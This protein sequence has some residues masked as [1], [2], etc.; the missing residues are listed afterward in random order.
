MLRT[1]RK[2]TLPLLVLAAACGGAGA[3]SAGD[4]WA[5]TIDT[6]GG[7]VI[8][9]NP[10]APLWRAGEEWRIEED[11][12]IGA[13]D[14]TG[15]DVF[16]N[17]SALAVAENGD[18]AV[19]DVQAFEVR[20]FDRDGRHLRSFGRSGS[21]PGEFRNPRSVHFDAQG[22]IWV[23]DA[24]N[25]RY[26]IFSREGALV[27]SRARPF[28]SGGGG[29]NP[30]VMTLDGRLI[31]VF[32]T[33]VREPDGTMAISLI[34]ARLA[35]A[36]GAIDTFP[37]L[38]FLRVP[39]PNAPSALLPF[40]P[41]TVNTFDLHGGT[42]F[43]PSNG[44]R[45]HHR[46]PAGDTTR[47]IEWSRVARAFAR[48][49]EDSV[50]TIIAGWPEP[51]DRAALGIGPQRIRG[52]HVDE[53]GRLFVQSAAEHVAGAGTSFEAFDADGRHL[54]RIESNVRF[55]ATP[56]PL[57]RGGHVYGVTID[58]LGVPAVARAAL[59]GP[60]ARAQ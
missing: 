5:G 57:F 60:G 10:A 42:W 51:L 15:A 27:D 32:S 1:L 41:R 43:A 38:P 37:P 53:D 36:S 30:G 3:G 40:M 22:R 46:T 28:G 17:I 16:G 58:E 19:L 33:L 56:P 20:L 55:E 52:L 9:T 39:A 23:P 8:V 47:I 26:H 7:R 59:R 2:L 31:D 54:G 34:G 13:L 6:V 4:D 29:G 35:A 45:I 12:R 18:I 50:A 44:E 48:W 14:G 24:A 25:A 11:L 49:E 21:G